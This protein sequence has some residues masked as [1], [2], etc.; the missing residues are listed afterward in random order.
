MKNKLTE[1]GRKLMALFHRGQFHADLEEE[2]RLHQELREQENIADRL[3]PDEAHYSAQRRFGN[4]LVWRE[5]SRERAVRCG[6]GTG[7]KHFF[8]TFATACA[9]FDEVPG[10]RL[11][12]SA[13]SPFSATAAAKDRVGNRS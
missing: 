12:P 13:P 2:M 8:K 5:E 11:S 1:L 4:K 3:A 7:S 10:S 9:S 6:A